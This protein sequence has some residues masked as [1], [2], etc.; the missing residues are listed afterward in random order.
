MQN[1][2]ESKIDDTMNGCKCESE[3][4]RS[5]KTSFCQQRIFNDSEQENKLNTKNHT[6]QL[7]RIEHSTILGVRF[8][9]N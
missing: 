7:I 2:F 5:M 3:G 1:N 4:K 9:R 8:Y 6:N